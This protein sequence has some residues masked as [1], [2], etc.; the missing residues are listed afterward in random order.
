MQN[1]FSKGL[2]AGLTAAGTKPAAEISGFCK[3]YTRGFVLGYAY[4]RAEIIGDENA[5]AFEA[6][7]LSREY[8]LDRELVAEFFSDSANR[9]SK[10]FFF[11]G[12]EESRA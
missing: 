8:G 5:A 1:H 11:A 4:R 9:L 10:R 7:Q 12:Y 6:G 2:M 3:D